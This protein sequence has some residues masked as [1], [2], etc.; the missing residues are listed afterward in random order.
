MSHREFQQLCRETWKMKRTCIII[1]T[2]PERELKVSLVFGTKEKSH[3]M[4]VY[5]IQILFNFCVCKI[6]SIF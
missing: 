5:Q 2:D 4:S 3:I 1:M 6:R